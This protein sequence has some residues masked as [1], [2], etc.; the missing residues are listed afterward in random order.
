MKGSIYSY[1]TDAGKRWR[2]DL[3]LNSNRYQKAGFTLK[4]EAEDWLDETVARYSDIR[5]VDSRTL[6]VYLQWWLGSIEPR[7]SP[8]TVERYRSL[9]AHISKRIG[10]VRLSKLDA[11]T[12]EGALTELARDGMSSPTVKHVRDCVRSALGAAVRLK[13]LPYN[14]ALAVVVAKPDK[15]ERNA[16]DEDATRAYMAAADQ[17]WV[18]PI[19]R[20]AAATGA[21]RGELLALRWTDIDWLTATLRIERSIVVVKGQ[22]VEKGTKTKQSRNV[23]LPTSA[24]QV[25]AIHKERQEQER[26]MYGGKWEGNLIFC[27]PGGAHLRPGSVSRAC[28]R[29][30]EE[31]GVTDGGLQVLR[32]SHGSQLLSAGSPLPAVSKRLGHSNVNTTAT[33]YAHALSRDEEEAA[34]LIEGRIFSSAP[35]CLI[36]AKEEEASKDA[37]IQ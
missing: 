31:A 2:V 1:K 30:A 5:T 35:K 9:A 8:K 17:T 33:V 10:D 12:L 6:G 28:R 34:E 36:E 25:L 4:R 23:K 13:I 11:L 21:R 15:K 32:H 16:I 27:Q 20:L 18:G 22:I 14:V 29:I 24:V 26:G 19:I 37:G 7:L 3:K